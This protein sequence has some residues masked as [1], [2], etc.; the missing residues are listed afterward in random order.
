MTSSVTSGSLAGGQDADKTHVEVLN[1][2]LSTT[3]TKTSNVGTYPISGSYDNGNYAV[4][5]SGSYTENTTKG[6]YTIGKASVTATIS[7]A[8]KTYGQNDPTF[9]FAVT[10]GIV[11][12]DAASSLGLTLVRDKSR[13]YDKHIW[14]KCSRFKLGIKYW[15]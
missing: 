2:T 15:F 13:I 6:T 10:S 1:L 5:F 3:A 11:N 7:D 4:T 14:F 9:D 8:S 12:P